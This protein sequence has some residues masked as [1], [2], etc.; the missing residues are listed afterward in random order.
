MLEERI[1]ETSMNERTNIRILKFGYENEYVKTSV[2][3]Q[4]FLIDCEK[5]KMS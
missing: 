3:E 1:V 2:K 5:M 4:L